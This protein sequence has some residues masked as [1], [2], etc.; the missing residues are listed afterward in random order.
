MFC[1]GGP[2]PELPPPVAERLSAVVEKYGNWKV[3]ELQ[4]YIKKLMGWNIKER[5]AAYVGHTVYGYF[6]GE[7]YKFTIHEI[8]K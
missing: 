2:A 8:C 4:R 1:Y 5:Y 3:W 7:G 6:Y